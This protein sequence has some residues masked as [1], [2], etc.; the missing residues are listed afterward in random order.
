MSTSPETYI[1]VTETDGSQ[2]I[3]VTAFDETLATLKGLLAEFEKFSR[4]GSAIAHEANESMRA[5][6]AAIAKAES[7]R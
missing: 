7:Q 3:S 2:W 1:R 6:R 5:A 4:Y